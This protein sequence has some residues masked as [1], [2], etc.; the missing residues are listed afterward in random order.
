MET[1]KKRVLIIGGG[2]SGLVAAIAA[3]RH[4][5][6][7]TVLEKKTQVGKKLLVTGNGRCNLTNRDQ[8]LSHYHCGEPDFPGKALEA[9][10]YGETL[11]FFKELGVYPKDRNG[12]LYPYSQQAQA[13]ADIL[14]LEAEGRKVKLACNTQIL[15]MEKREGRFFV[16]TPGWTYEGEAL[17]LACGSMASSLGGEDGY[18]YARGFGHDIRR[19]LP[20]LVQL[21]G[22]KDW[23]RRLAGIRLDAAVSLYGDGELLGRD[24]GEV[25]MTDYGLSGIPVFQVSGYASQ[26]LE[27]GQ[28]VEAEL[29]LLPEF[30]DTDK[31]DML[32]SI[33]KYSGGK[34]AAAC[35]AG[36]FPRKL[37]P[38]LLERA[39]I[40]KECL[41]R[42]M[43]GRRMEGLLREI[44][45]FRV[46]ITATNGFAQ[47]QVCRG[48]VDV[49]Q[50]EPATMG[51]RL[52]KGLYFAGELLDVDGD[53]GGY[54][55]QWAWSSG[56]LAGRAAAGED[57]TEREGRP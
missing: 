13:V 44:S 10:G 9:F 48:G 28:R 49:S 54:N 35:L 18:A 36:V 16:E 43:T 38:E 26:A 17:I 52:V 7:V 34:Q 25:Q 4:G 27:N 46:P 21:R 29:A 20:S 39:G 15:G 41:A 6:K 22:G 24:T 3:A 45:H 47:A 56:Y 1:E 37:I 5:A 11:A 14:R 40:E 19:T 32:R 42:D 57:R 51:S 30:S 12:Y 53:C 2:A 31:R 8:R 55:L 33:V 23:P 50:V